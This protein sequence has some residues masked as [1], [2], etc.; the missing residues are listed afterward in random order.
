MFAAFHHAVVETID[1]K[2]LHW[3]NLDCR[4]VHLQI[5]FPGLLINDLATATRCCS[6][7]EMLMRL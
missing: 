1:A 3:Q 2:T 7:P 4:L 5:Q 6:P